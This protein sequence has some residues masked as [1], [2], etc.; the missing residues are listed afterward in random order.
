MRI[1]QQRNVIV[2]AVTYRDSAPGIVTSPSAAKGWEKLDLTKL[3]EGDFRMY[4]N[5]LYSSRIAAAFAG[6][7]E[8]SQ[9][10]EGNGTKNEAA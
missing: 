10:N 3:F 5:G 2:K 7:E 1:I 9:P 8:S 4:P 6:A